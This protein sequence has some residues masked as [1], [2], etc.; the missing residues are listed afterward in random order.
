VVGHAIGLESN[1]ASCDYVKLYNG[2]TDT[3]AQSFQHIRQVSTEILSGIT[4]P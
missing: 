2:D 1:S 4:P 3:L